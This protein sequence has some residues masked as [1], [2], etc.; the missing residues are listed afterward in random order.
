MG[1]EREPAKARSHGHG[2]VWI[3]VSAL[4]PAGS[5][6]GVL[7]PVWRPGPWPPRPATIMTTA[8]TTRTKAMIPNTFTQRGVP[9]VCVPFS[10]TSISSVAGGR[11]A[12][13]RDRMSI[14]THSVSTT[15]I[16]Y[17]L[18]IVPKLWSESIE[19][20]RRAVREATL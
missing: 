8:K 12:D 16:A 19:A 9:T 7:S 5:P 18:R 1:S 10:A 17:I 20:H 14:L 6:D 13:V 3:P 4:W 15:D 2:Y 11:W